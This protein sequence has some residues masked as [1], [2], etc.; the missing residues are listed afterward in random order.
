MKKIWEKI[1]TWWGK[2]ALPWIK[3][4]W[5]QIINIIVVFI[6]YKTFN[7]IG[8]VPGV[9]TL[10]GFWGFALLVYY[11]FWKFF[12]LEKYFIKK[13][14]AKPQPVKPINPDKPIIPYEPDTTDKTGGDKDESGNY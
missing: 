13:E 8:T 14:E 2:T 12:G 7:E 4:S 5:M 10:L 11:I 1:K 6:A 3:I 9:E